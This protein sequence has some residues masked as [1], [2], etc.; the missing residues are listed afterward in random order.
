VNTSRP[1]AAGCVVVGRGAGLEPKTIAPGTVGQVLTQ[2]TA[3]ISP[4]FAAPAAVNLATGTTGILPLANGGT[5]QGIGAVTTLQFFGQLSAGGT[6]YIGAVADATE[7]NVA[8]RSSI[9]LGT[10]LRI[11]TA[12]SVAPGAGE[13]YVYVLRVAGADT[14]LTTTHAGGGG[15]NSGASTG[16]VAVAGGQ[17]MAVKVTASAGAAPAS[18]MVMTTARIDG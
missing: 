10:V 18:H 4:A 17:R 15:N 5:G 16:A 11:D 12:S 1:L 8:F 14:A 3:G 2:V 6:F 13:T 9:V 7:N